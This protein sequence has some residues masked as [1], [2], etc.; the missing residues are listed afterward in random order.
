M[1][2]N[3][4]PTAVPT[5][6]ELYFSSLGD[7][8]NLAEIVTRFVEE[9]PARLREM[10]SQFIRAD[11]DHLSS[12]AHQIKGAAGSYGF[13]QVTPFAARLEESLHGGTPVGAIRAALEDLTA[14]CRRMRAGAPNGDSNSDTVADLRVLIANAGKP[15]PA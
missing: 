9:I 15:D 8:P 2:S 12:L 14:A 13:M 1:A 6:N 11:W 3:D 10:N 7:D 4:C 5:S